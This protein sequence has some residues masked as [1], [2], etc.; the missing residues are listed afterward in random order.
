MCGGERRNG[1]DQ[2]SYYGDQFHFQTVL[3]VKEWL[4]QA[5]PCCWNGNYCNPAQGFTRHCGFRP[6][7]EKYAELS[8]IAFNNN[9]YS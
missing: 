7:E 9:Y 6:E 3:M 2:G 4:G 5:M 1:Q 8:K